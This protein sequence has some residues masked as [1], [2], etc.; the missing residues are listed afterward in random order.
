MPVVT[1]FNDRN[2][3]FTAKITIGI[4]K[5]TKI[6]FA[7]DDLSYMKKL[8]TIKQFLFYFHEPI[9][10]KLLDRILVYNISN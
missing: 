6:H 1:S 4:N 2:L 9:F 8:V 3:L 10:K 5:L 7:V